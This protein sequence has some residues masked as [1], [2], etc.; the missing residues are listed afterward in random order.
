MQS[1]VALIVMMISFLGYCLF[2]MRRTRVSFSFAPALTVAS[3]GSLLFV[4]GIL[5]FLKYMLLGLYGVGCFFFLWECVRILVQKREKT[6]LGAHKKDVILLG[7]WLI[8]NVYFVWL[9]KNAHPLHYDN[10]TH[11]ATIPKILLKEDR[12]PAFQESFLSHQSY[13]VGSALFIYYVCRFTKGSDAFYS[14]AQCIALLSFIF[15]LAHFVKKKW[16]YALVVFFGIF[17][18]CFNTSITDLLVDTLMPLL[19]VA[20]F[21]IMEEESLPLK[22]RNLLIIPFLIFLMN[23]K[24]VAIFFMMVFWAYYLIR[25]KM[26]EIKSFLVAH[27]LAPLLT[28]FIWNRHIALVFIGGN[29][30]KHALTPGH[31]AATA[32]EKTGA[33]KVAILKAYAGKVFSL[34]NTSL[35]YMFIIAGV[36]L[37]AVFMVKEKK[38]H[39]LRTR[40][41]GAFGLYFFYAFMMGGMYIFSMPLAEAKVVAEFERYMAIIIPCILG[42]VLLSI[43]KELEENK[44][45]T[46]IL[47]LALSVLPIF[48]VRDKLD[49]LYRRQNYESSLRYALE[50]ELQAVNVTEDS[51]L[52]VY[53]PAPDGGYLEFYLQYYIL[54]EKMVIET[55][56]EFVPEDIADYFTHVV[57]LGQDE[58]IQKYLRDVGKEEL[59]GKEFAVFAK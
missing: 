22:K 50:K 17:V 29:M 14:I 43:L 48:M 36:I 4:A 27:V 28:M 25:N 16:P 35:I 3:I 21:G 13:P 10:F 56:E 12:L 11:W 7:V 34:Q 24:N 55:A 41:W 58:Q 30:S 37:I 15:P 40:F 52:F 2:F 45:I 5:N 23:V 42:C 54:S 53:E 8:L 47:M 9:L 57:I 39:F 38:G 44:V 18:L 59:I 1:I 31:F 19:G 33:D 20:V 26:Q 46:V 6:A 51:V 49:T 32:A